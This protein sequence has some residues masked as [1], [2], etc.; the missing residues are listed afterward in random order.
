MFHLFQT[1]RPSRSQIRLDLYTY[2]LKQHAKTSNV[3]GSGPGS[4]LGDLR[5]SKFGRSRTCSGILFGDT[6]NSRDEF[7]P[8]LPT[9]TS[10]RLV[11]GCGILI[12]IP[13][14]ESFQG[15]FLIFSPPRLPTSPLKVRCRASLP[16]GRLVKLNNSILLNESLQ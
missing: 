6:K 4:Y 2:I 7:F 13:K 3:P 11:P 12:Q 10:F 15:L 8:E 5:S 16:A 14:R 9:R 1:S